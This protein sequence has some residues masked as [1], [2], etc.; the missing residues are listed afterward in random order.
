MN[1]SAVDIGRGSEATIAGVTDGSGGRELIMISSISG[2]AGVDFG[3]VEVVEELAGGGGGGG[4]RRAELDEDSFFFDFS[5]SLSL[6]F[7]LS[8]PFSSI[9]LTKLLTK[10]P[11]LELLFFSFFSLSS[12]LPAALL[13]VLALF[14]SLP[15]IS[16]RSEPGLPFL[17]LLPPEGVVEAAVVVGTSF[18][19]SLPFPLSFDVIEVEFDT[20]VGRGRIE[21]A[22][23]TT[24][25]KGVEVPGV[26]GIEEV[27]GVGLFLGS[28]GKG[29][30]FGIV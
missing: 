27:E 29:K 22:E 5:L 18:S 20:V 21:S 10:P 14:P 30:A 8:L 4:G 24:P 17:L 15:P 23:G 3:I 2:T 1:D 9:P 16:S 12:P 6:S 11:T 13:V 26:G 25:F 28:G 7:S 19:L